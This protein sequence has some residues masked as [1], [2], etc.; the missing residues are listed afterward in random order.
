MVISFT[1]RYIGN[2]EGREGGREGEIK[3]AS[4]PAPF[5]ANSCAGAIYRF[6]PL[7]LLSTAVSDHLV[8]ILHGHCTCTRESV[9]VSIP[10]SIQLCAIYHHTG[11][12]SLDLIN[13]CEQP[14]D[15]AQICCTREG[16]RERE[17]ACECSWV[18]EPSSDSCF[19][20]SI[21]SALFPAASCVL[22]CSHQ[23]LSSY[24]LT[25]TVCDHLIFAGP[26]V[27]GVGGG[28][29]GVNTRSE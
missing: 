10:V 29:G 17:K 5:L 13:S 18:G 1:V 19:T 24:H 12:L 8:Y 6:L 4:I 14:S 25:T 3:G 21:N 22:P 20:P 9:G 26:T 11:V 23:F 2:P 15:I 28:R 16:E 27:F 7:A